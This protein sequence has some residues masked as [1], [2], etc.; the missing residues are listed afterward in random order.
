[1]QHEGD[2]DALSYYAVLAL[3]A[4]SPQY[5]LQCARYLSN[6]V[7]VFKEQHGPEY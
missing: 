2:T 5:A 1:M 6:E 4:A 7:A 3:L